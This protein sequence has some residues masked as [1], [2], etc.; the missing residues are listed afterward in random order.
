VNALLEQI[1]ALSKPRKIALLGVLIVLLAALDYSFLYSP[2]A[3]RLADL[4]GR[5][6]HLK[7]EREKKTRLA[8]NRPKLREELSRLEAM[9]KEA[10]AQLPA[11]K[12]IPDLLKTIA[13]KAR[14]SGLEVVLFRPRGENYREFYAEVP[15]EIMVRGEFHDML[16]FF[17]EVG[18]LSRL[19]NLSN[20]ELRRSKAK[21]GAG[22]M[23]A[24]TVATAFRFLDA[25]ERERIAAEKAAKE[26]A[27]K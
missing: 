2:L 17:D 27:K 10:V 24:V 26:K 11:R 4:R 22:P 18:K 3:A 9:L 20:L 25:A 15:V 19:V 12:E 1:F 8:A 6:E 13:A 21:N 16:A 23:E 7:A 14:E 5:L